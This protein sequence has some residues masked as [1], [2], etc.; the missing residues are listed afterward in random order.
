M[1][2]VDRLSRLEYKVF[3]RELPSFKAKKSGDAG[4]TSPD[5]DQEGW[6]GDQ[7]GHGLCVIEQLSR[8]ESVLTR[9]LSSF[10]A[11]WNGDVGAVS[12]N[13]TQ[14]RP[15]PSDLCEG[16]DHHSVVPAAHMRLHGE[17]LEQQQQQQSENELDAGVEP[18][19]R[20]CA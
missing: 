11:T 3:G 15:D 12:P 9:E 1:S 16:Q 20:Q 5:I 10:T 6:A 2:V 17:G 8:L 7:E 18:F 19:R 13:N 14:P 4:V